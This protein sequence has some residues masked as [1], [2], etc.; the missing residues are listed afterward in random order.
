MAED[1]ILAVATL[2]FSFLLVVFVTL[3]CVLATFFWAQR[4]S[5][6]ARAFVASGLAILIVL[7]PVVGV[8][9]MDA[10][11]SSALALLIGA[12]VMFMITFPVAFL[13]TRKLDRRKQDIGAIFE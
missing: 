13:A 8:L 10:E 9:T 2:A 4:L 12:L 11:P 1:V 5:R 7:G 6:S 3:G